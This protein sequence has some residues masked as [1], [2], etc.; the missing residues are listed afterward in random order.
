MR[1]LNIWETKVIPQIM[2]IG[3]ATIFQLA[4]SI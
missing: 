1:Y 2:L 3:A 4:A